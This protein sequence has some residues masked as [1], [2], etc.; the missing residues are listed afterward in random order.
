[1][2]L[3]RL[4]I[5]VAL[6]VM[7]GSLA[8]SAQDTVKAHWNFD[9]AKDGTTRDIVGGV[10]DA[11]GGN[12]RL[13]QGVKGKALVL[14]GYTTRIS[15]AADVAPKLGLDFTVEAWIALGAYP[16]NW[17]PIAA[18]ENTVSLNS[19]LDSAC[20]PDDITVNSPRD[21]FFFGVGPQGQLGLFAGAGDWMVCQTERMISLRKWTHVAA[22][23]KSGEGIY[24]YIN[25]EKVA[26]S[27]L[28]ANFRP[29]EREE[30]RVGMAR[31]KLE[32]SNPVRPFATLA[33]WYS[34]DGILDELRI[35]DTALSAVEI[36]KRYAA[37]QPDSEPDLP[38][39][40]LPSGPGGQGTFGASYQNL[41]YYPEWDSLW[42]VSSDPD[43]VVQ[44]DDTPVRV[45]FWR[46][47]RYSPAWVMENGMWMADQSIENFNDDDGCIEHMLDPRC[48]FSHVRIIENTEARVVVHWRYCPTSANDRHSQVDPV[49]GWEDW[50]DEYHTYY[51][52]AIG[53]RKVI[54]HTKGQFLWPEEVIALCHPGQKPEDVVDMAAMTLANLKG[55]SHTYTWAGKT[56]ELREGD[57]YLHFGNGPEERPV[58]MRVNM[59]SEIKPFQIFETNN[60]FRIFASE[61]RKGFSQFPWWNHWPVAQIPSDGRYCQAPDRASHFSLA[62]GGPPPHDGGDGS[63]WWAWM[64]GAT[65]GSAESLVPLA[66]SW[67]LPPKVTVERGDVEV[68]YDL[69]QRCFVLTSRSKPS[70]DLCL[71][72]EAESGSPIFNPAFLVEN[73]GDRDV[74]LR[75]DGRDVPRG[76][77][78]RFGRIRRINRYDLIVWV[79]LESKRPVTIELISAGS[80]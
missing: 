8:L 32:P 50:V 38:T 79:R 44:F 41:K 77:D 37:E 80:D 59:K 70:E 66:R 49:T 35:H 42:P 13:V 56:P 73:W 43:I 63:F 21:G 31:Q 11:V 19:N 14:D 76:A 53:L 46:G 12:F 30:L 27:P 62:W 55:Q 51:P 71:R 18:Q 69:T 45:V 47:T 1:M 4:K 26:E 29:A 68:R 22:A 2:R 25:G 28:A 20:W 40:I 6:F 33:C 34:L 74:R 58:I 48:R 16:W 3:D 7:A 57:R 64:Y 36:K 17:A 78:F 39:R 65:S 9:E 24:L 75:I 54:Q 15:R 60:R 67:L 5:G 10:D 52:D 61:H 72:L 23:F